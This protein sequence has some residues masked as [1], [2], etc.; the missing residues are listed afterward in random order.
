MKKLVFVFLFSMLWAN[1]DINNTKKIK[2]TL[3]EY[4]LIKIRETIDKLE[5]EMIIKTVKKLIFK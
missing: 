4:K 1:K 2:K 3:E 5:R